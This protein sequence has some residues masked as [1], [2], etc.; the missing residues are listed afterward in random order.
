MKNKAK[1]WF[2]II[3]YDSSVVHNSCSFDYY[4]ENYQ[5]KNLEIFNMAYKIQQ[6][7]IRSLFKSNQYLK[8][9]LIFL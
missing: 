4:Y 3:K 6:Y 9:N 1:N 7:Y 8:E 2:I 5:I